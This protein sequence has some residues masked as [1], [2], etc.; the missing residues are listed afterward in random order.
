MR[1][2][3]L[4]LLSFF[5][6]ACDLRPNTAVSTPIPTP[7]LAPIVSLPHTPTPLPRP[8]ELV[9]QATATAD[10]T[11]PA[12]TVLVY[13]AADN[14]LDRAALL[15]LNEM[16]AALN[17]PE[18]QVV[19][20][21][22]RPFDAEWS[23][24]RRYLITP[25]K[26]L[27]AFTT[28][29]VANLGEANMGDPEILAD[30]IRWGQLTYP[31][32]QTA[33]VVWNH[34]RAWQGIAYDDSASD[35]LD[36]L[37]LQEGLALA[38]ADLA[39]IGFDACLMGQLEL[40]TAIAPYARV[41]V[42]SAE[43]TPGRGWP[44]TA[45]L[46][47]L[48][49]QPAVNATQL[50]QIIVG[51]FG[52][53]Y[54]RTQP[55]AFTTLTAVDL[56][57]LTAVT[58]HL[59][60]LTSQLNEELPFHA[61]SLG[62]AR[63]GAEAYA[64]AYGREAEQYAL[65]DVAHFA[66]ILASR[67]LDEAVQGTAEALRQSVATAVLAHHHGLGLPQ[68]SGLSLY[69]PRTAAQYDGNYALQSPLPAWDGFLKAYHLLGS[70][71][72]SA[73]QIAITTTNTLTTSTQQPALLRFQL[74]GRDIEE[75]VLLVGQ[76]TDSGRR[77]FTYDPLIPEPNYLPSGERLYTWRDGLH[78]DFYVWQSRAPFLGDGNAGSFVVL[79]PSYGYT[80][81]LRTV[82]G[83]FFSA[84]G[85][86]PIVANLTIDTSSRR[87]TAV[88]GYTATGYPY[89]LAPQTGDAF[90]PFQLFWASNG[91]LS[92]RSGDPLP[93]DAVGQLPFSWQPLPSGDYVLGFQASNRAGQMGEATADLLVDNDEQLHDT[94]AYL[95]PYLGYQFN[96]PADWY[97]PTYRDTLLYT[98]NLSG[99]TRLQVTL[100]PNLVSTSPADLKRQALTLFGGVTV[101]Y[102]DELVITNY[103]ALR[104]A[105]GYT[106]SDGERTGILLT[107]VRG[108]VGFVID[109]DG[110]TA[111]EAATLAFVE[112]LASSWQFR[113]VSAEGLFPGH[114]GQVTQLGS[115]SLPR[116]A[117]FRYEA[118]GGDWQRLT[119]AQDARIFAAF[120]TEPLGTRPLNDTVAHWAQ[121]ASQGVANYVPGRLGRYALANQLWL[122][123]D[124]SY[125][126]G[127]N[128]EVWG[129][130]LAT[131][132][133][134][135]Q[136]VAWMEAPAAVYGEVFGRVF[137]PLLSAAVHN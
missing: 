65:V 109:V 132:Q 108:N 5:L 135:Q 67:S 75:V 124:F 23:D 106:G 72:S 129:M 105:Y 1:Y 96:Y 82:A 73:P 18:V 56:A 44:Y 53:Y 47:Q 78:E 102:E 119:A 85:S 28:P 69:F 68:S 111:E 21:L 121:V 52:D 131:E 32:N 116:P 6:V 26:D 70:A 91:L 7:T 27:Q 128:Q 81:T 12:W 17:S 49:S 19:V 35:Y 33:L 103:G 38:S 51:H 43:L 3:P 114:W 37:E 104:T 130:V 87:Q 40:F 25:D 94:I 112:Q 120:R 107:F 42:A 2:F 95:D 61:A 77:L 126:D 45:I 15:N 24:T 29:P 16:E 79:W 113:P 115:F 118:V 55:D 101:L 8:T 60:D 64:R 125:R 58:N 14:N 137:E 9:P 93:F 50:G 11:L 62:T 30:F 41:G 10:P 123:Q 92:Q 133:N 46:N 13:M 117:D 98:T 74:T 97:R 80:S 88:W 71:D 99:T 39:L 31:A 20:Q 110:P 122:R 57:A 59:S 22:D 89:A 127:N 84:D 83:Q 66:Q 76:E 134:G 54:T 86:P 4:L 90:A 48:A 34:G 136:V 36:L 100:Y 63:S